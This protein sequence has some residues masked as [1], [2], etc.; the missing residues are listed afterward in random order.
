[1][2]IY[3]S[4]TVYIHT[5]ILFEVLFKQ[6]LITSERIHVNKMLTSCVNHGFFHKSDIGIKKSNFQYQIHPNSLKNVRLLLS[7]IDYII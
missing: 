5:H 6:P 3:K 4:V 1:M 2:Y 7:Y